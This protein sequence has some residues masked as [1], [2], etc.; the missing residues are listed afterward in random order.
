[1]IVNIIKENLVLQKYFFEL[2]FYC[3]VYLK[4]VLYGS[5]W[6]GSKQKI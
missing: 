5:W 4:N 1:M 3:A 6:Q 2:R